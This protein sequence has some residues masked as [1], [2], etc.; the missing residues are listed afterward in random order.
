MQIDKEIDMQID[1]DMLID[2][3]TCDDINLSNLESM[4]GDRIMS[5]SGKPDYTS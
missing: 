3:Y 1:K 4:P 5:I 2:I